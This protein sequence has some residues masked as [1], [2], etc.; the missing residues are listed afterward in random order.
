M[1]P[2]SLAAV[3]DVDGPAA[4]PRSNGE[5]VFGAPWESRAFG[6]VLALNAGGTFEWED[7]R[8]QL[9]QAISDWEREHDPEEE[10]SYY[11]CWLVALERLL[12]ERGL[13]RTGDMV[14]RTREFAARPHGHDHRHDHDSDHH[15]HD[16]HHDEHGC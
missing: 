1:A 16:H 14:A 10:W 15:H 8:L 7:F 2:T 3:L 12:A 13:V 6:L 4:P 11:R 9:I 5:L